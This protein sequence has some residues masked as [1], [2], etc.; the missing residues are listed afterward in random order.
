MT[1]AQP[2]HQTVTP[3]D[4]RERRLAGQ[5]RGA[6]PDRVRACLDPRLSDAVIQRL[7]DSER[8]ASRVA[9][10]ML[11]RH[12]LEPQALDRLHGSA[13]PEPGP[14]ADIHSLLH[15]DLA[16]CA[17]LS[18]A[19][20][21]ARSLKQCVSSKVVAEL[22]ALIGQRARAFGL[23]NADL[24]VSSQV[25]TGAAELAA[26]INDDGFRC[27]GAL[28]SSKD[29]VLR[30]LVALRLPP[31]TPEEAAGFGQEHLRHAS[32]IIERSLAEL[33]GT[34]DVS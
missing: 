19:A 10:V 34:P 18:G 12:G 33:R 21:H 26:A 22:T 8:L 11:H 3:N 14:E 1:S 25:L 23:R 24:A 6:N 17:W 28:L 5:L 20:W 31:G 9:E 32:V 7:A 4:L 30:G 2:G 13:P 29:A 27:I 16:Q 15:C